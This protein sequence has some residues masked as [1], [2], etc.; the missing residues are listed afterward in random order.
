MFKFEYIL[1][2]VV[3]SALI[4]AI[5][6]IKA[7]KNRPLPKIVTVCGAIGVLMALWWIQ[8]KAG[9]SHGMSFYSWPIVVPLGGLTGL[10]LGAI[11]HLIGTGLL[12]LRKT[13]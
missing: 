10:F 2:F 6:L 11:L 5:F 9:G 13:N 12:K 3:A 8:E 7:S 4:F 1:W